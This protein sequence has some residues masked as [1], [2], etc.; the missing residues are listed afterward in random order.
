M[1][2]VLFAEGVN[3]SAH[4]P[5]EINVTNKLQCLESTL[6]CG[7]NN[8]PLVVGKLLYLMPE[9]MATVWK[10]VKKVLFSSRLIVQVLLFA[11]F[12]LLFALPA[13]ST[14]Q[15]REVGFF[16]SAAPALLLELLGLLLAALAALA[17]LC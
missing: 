10:I 7:S 15:K 16:F 6:F 11:I 12:S 8:I 17:A 14:Y 3:S 5:S 4:L 1:T 2:N 9:K 13:I